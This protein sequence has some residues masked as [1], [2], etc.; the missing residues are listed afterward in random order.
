MVRRISE[1]IYEKE[2]LDLRDIIQE[3]VKD[4]IKRSVQ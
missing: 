2:L 3:R 1:E 4:E